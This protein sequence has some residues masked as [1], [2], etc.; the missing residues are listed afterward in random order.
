MAHLSG[1]PQRSA[2]TTVITMSVSHAFTDINPIAQTFSLT[3][4]S[5]SSIPKTIH[6]THEKQR[7]IFSQWHHSVFKKS[8]SSIDILIPML[9]QMSY[10]CRA[11]TC[12][13]LLN[14]YKNSPVGSWLNR[15]KSVH[16]FCNR[17]TVRDNPAGQCFLDRL[18]NGS[19]CM[20]S[21]ARLRICIKVFMYLQNAMCV[22]ICLYMQNM[23]TYVNVCMWICWLL[24]GK[25]SS[26]TCCSV[27]EWRTRD[28]VIDS[29]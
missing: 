14:W 15:Q 19:I 21:S 7:A 1:Y 10:D 11:T 29:L 28:L 17:E 23:C 24:S 5:V 20:L 8:Q 22:Y 9:I 18:V 13:L 12:D 27:E 16:T 26:S 25:I 3:S 6:Y 2:N 4:Q